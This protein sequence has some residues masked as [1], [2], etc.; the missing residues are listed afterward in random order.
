MNI[1]GQLVAALVTGMLVGVFVFG[2]LW[3]TVRRGLTSPNP[4]LW[5][6]VS[7][8]LRLG[9]VFAAFYYMALAGLPSVAMCLL[10]LLVARF[11]ATRLVHP[12]RKGRP[13]A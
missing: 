11:A 3:W 2:G 10:G 7:S 13:C 9:A 4:A 6:G 12:V 1:E 8:L 5:F